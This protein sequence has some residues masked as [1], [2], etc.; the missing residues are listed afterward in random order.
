MNDTFGHD[1]GDKLLIDVSKRIKAVI[2]YRD[3]V[4]RFGGD[5]FTV[6][7]FFN[8]DRQEISDLAKKNHTNLNETLYF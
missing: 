3:N 5:E 1:A 2:N 6:L 7:A 8:D 4:F